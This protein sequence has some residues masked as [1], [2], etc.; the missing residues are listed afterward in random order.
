MRLNIKELR[1]SRTGNTIET[2]E[3]E[4]LKLFQDIAD[5][6]DISK[7]ALIP[8]SRRGI[9]ILPKMD[10][11][12]TQENDLILILKGFGY[13]ERYELFP[14]LE[15]LRKCNTI[16]VFD[17]VCESGTT[18]LNYER[19]LIDLTNRLKLNFNR[20][21]IRF[22]THVR[23]KSLR[24]I[25]MHIPSALSLF[26]RIY[27]ASFL[28]GN[29]YEEKILDLYMAIASRGAILDADHM[30]IKAS[31]DGKKD[32]FEVWER[33]EEI[34]KTNFCDLV[35]DGIEFLHPKR[36]KLG[37]YVQENIKKNLIDLGLTFPDFVVG[38]DIAK[39]RMVFNLEFEEKGG[40]IAVYTTGFEGVP[41]INPII[42]DFSVDACL[43]S[44]CPSFRFCENG[45]ISR[46]FCSHEYLPHSKYLSENYRHPR[47][48]CIVG[49]LV[50]QFEEHIWEE[51][52]SQF[53]DILPPSVE[54]LHLDRVK[55]QRE[56]QYL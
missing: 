24:N 40:K 48:D 42:K 16:V 36:K 49:D 44:W 33:F 17:D 45:L 50:R 30:L 5:D 19:Y 43:S 9:G 27:S 38:I 37:L 55:Q 46:E 20:K 2:A 56:L 29:E 32:F 11:G 52:R 51:I 25:L 13:Y 3:K 8:L 1:P 6:F 7:T 12:E 4:L 54:W 15:K 31:F 28:R 10:E 18:L 53:E 22:A 14:L 26:G 47:Y 35:E 39:F 41:I 34:A 21:N 23:K